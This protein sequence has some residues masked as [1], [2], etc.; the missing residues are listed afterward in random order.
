MCNDAC[1]SAGQFRTDAL[2][3]VHQHPARRNSRAAKRPAIEPPI[4]TALGSV[5]AF[6][7]PS[8]MSS[9]PFDCSPNPIET[10]LIYRLINYY[11]VIALCQLLFII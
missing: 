10:H 9:P 11:E 3:H 8:F 5:R 7:R 4:T 1:A 6:P 2:I